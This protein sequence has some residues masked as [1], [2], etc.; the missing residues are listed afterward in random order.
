MANENLKKFLD[1]QGVKHLWGKIAEKIATEESRAQ[2][3]EQQLSDRIGTLPTGTSATN[4][5]GYIDEVT[6]GLASD[7]KIATL[8]SRVDTLT[9]DY[10]TLN[11]TVATINSTYASKEA[12]ATVASDL[13]VVASATSTALSNAATALSQI[14]AISTA[15]TN[16]A[17]ASDVATLA[18]S[19]ADTKKIVDDFFAEESNVAEKFDTLKEIVAYLDADTTDTVDI[20]TDLATLSNKVNTELQLGEYTSVSAYVDGAIATIIPLTND[21]I[22]EAISGQSDQT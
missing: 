18:S 17:E 9:S 22:D 15:L 11:S 14:S 4:V 6:S 12:L 19:Y 3:A 8:T 7:G 10:I 1:K 20:V 21:E 16:K 13:S 5:I 2:L